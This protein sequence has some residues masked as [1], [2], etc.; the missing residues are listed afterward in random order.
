MKAIIVGC[1]G[2]GKSVFTR[3]INKVLNYP[4]MHLDKVYHTVGKSHIT[5]EELV[6]AVNKF[7]SKHEKWIIDGNYISTLEFRVK[8]ADTV[9]LLNIPSEVCLR[10]IYYREEEYIKNCSNR[11]DM[12]KDFD[13][14][15][16]EEFASFVKSFEVDT[17][18]R[19]KEIVEK[20][21]EKI[22]IVINNYDEIEK[23][24]KDLSLRE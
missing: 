22:F 20:Y 6:E 12:S 23:V 16:T 3:R 9:I 2:A 19:V 14:T 17:L 13:G 10:N 7:A 11:E 1:P 21:K 18:P 4:V 15:V 5:R 8:L 24:I